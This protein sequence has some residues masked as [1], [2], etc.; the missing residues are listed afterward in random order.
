M[1]EKVRPEFDSS[2][3]W[4]DMDRFLENFDKIY[5]SH[6]RHWNEVKIKGK[7]IRAKIPNSEMKIWCSKFYYAFSL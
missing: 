4:M 1:K 5:V 6:V 2:V 7:F 3:F